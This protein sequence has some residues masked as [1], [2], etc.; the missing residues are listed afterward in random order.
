MNRETGFCIALAPGVPVCRSVE[1]PGGSPL[2]GILPATDFT[3]GAGPSTLRRLAARD[4]VAS[5]VLPPSGSS[6]FCFH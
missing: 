1:Y 2:G 3:R 5:L 4:L 6:F